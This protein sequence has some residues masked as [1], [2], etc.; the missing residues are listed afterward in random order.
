MTY[1]ERGA[2]RRHR[3][4]MKRVVI[5]T[6][7]AVLLVL[8]IVAVLPEHTASAEPQPSGTYRILS[9]K[10]EE[11]DSLWSIASEYFTE[12]FDSISSYIHEI[13]RMNGISSDMLYEGAYLVIPCYQ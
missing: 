3:K 2:Q 10:I 12:D 1:R 4:I 6:V 13:K 7:I 11:G 9:V 8:A 5:V